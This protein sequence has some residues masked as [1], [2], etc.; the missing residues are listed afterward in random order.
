[1]IETKK[2]KTDVFSNLKWSTA[3]RL[4]RESRRLSKLRFRQ[5]VDSVKKNMERRD[6][7]YRSLAMGDL[8]KEIRRRDN[9]SDLTHV[10]N[11]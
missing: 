7:V 11:Q 10:T 2:D 4:R 9:G 5:E 6:G 8:I 3:E 1:M